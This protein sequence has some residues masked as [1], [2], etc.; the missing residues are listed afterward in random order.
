MAAIC[1]LASAR[2]NE[3]VT[4]AG[5]SVTP[6]AE[7]IIRI[8]TGAPFAR[9]IRFHARGRARRPQGARGEFGRAREVQVIDK[10]HQHRTVR[11]RF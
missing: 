7:I 10:I 2:F 9:K 1:P 11:A 8:D 6:V 4:S 5:K 3:A